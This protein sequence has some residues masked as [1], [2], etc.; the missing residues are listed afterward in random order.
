MAATT[1]SARCHTPDRIQ[2]AAGQSR[3]KVDWGALRVAGMCIGVCNYKHIGTL[4]NAVRDAE[5]VNAKLNAV[6]GC[7][8]GI[9]KDPKTQID[10]MSSVRRFLDEPRLRE[11]PPELFVL[12]Y[13][14]HSLQREGEVY[15]VPTDAK[16]EDEAEDC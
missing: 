9:V 11:E 14:V 2:P 5:H 1:A 8:C 3:A 12:S 6:P 13:A 4:S 15:L 16:L 7:R 10:T